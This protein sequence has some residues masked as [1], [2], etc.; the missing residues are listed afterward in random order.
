M[1]GYALA[2]V[3]IIDAGWGLHNDVIGV[4]RAWSSCIRYLE[5]IC[6]C[7]GLD[8]CRDAVSDRQIT[9]QGKDSK[10]S[11]S[12]PYNRR[13]LDCRRLQ[14]FN[15]LWLPGKTRNPGRAASLG[16]RGCDGNKRAYLR[17]SAHNRFRFVHHSV[18]P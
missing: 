4:T 6:P 11:G 8:Y 5:A 15:F 13:V 3:L 2:P 17:F 12:I 14:L 7:S 16:T 9:R 1:I 18:R 10:L